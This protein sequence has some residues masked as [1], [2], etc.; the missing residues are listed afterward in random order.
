[1]IKFD[2]NL[3]LITLMAE[4]QEK[5]KFSTQNQAKIIAPKEQC[6]KFVQLSFLKL[7]KKYGEWWLV[8][9]IV[10]FC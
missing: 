9:H 1:M 3:F 4:N 8:L 10:P 7:R 5:V 2:G 6:F